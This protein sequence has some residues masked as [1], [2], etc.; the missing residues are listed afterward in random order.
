[1]NNKA[2]S[3]RVIGLDVLKFICCFLVVCI[4]VDL[5]EA[6]ELKFGVS[7]LIS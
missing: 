5:P 1:M 4:H 7:L 2:L 6:I 3:S